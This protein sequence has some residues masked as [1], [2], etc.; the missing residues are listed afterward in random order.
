MSLS[1][2]ISEHG[3]HIV[4][5]RTYGGG[6]IVA[7]VGQNV[8]GVTVGDEPWA[9]LRSVAQI[10]GDLVHEGSEEVRALEHEGLDEDVVL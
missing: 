10:F 5:G 8:V 7:V 6:K 1:C 9:D 3:A 2:P 4:E